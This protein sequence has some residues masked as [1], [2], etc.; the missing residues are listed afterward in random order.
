MKTTIV[1][2]TR[3][4]IIKLAPIIKKLDKRRYSVV[5]SGQHFEHKMGLQFIDELE[6]PK[7]N[8][9][10]KLTGKTP[11]IQISEIILKLSKILSDEKP[12]TV[13]V[14]GDTN[15][16]LAASICSIKQKIPISHVE[17]GLRSYDWRM[18]EEHN[19]IAVDH[20]S[21]VLFA[22]TSKSKQN[23]LSEN[24]HGSIH[25]TGN[26]VIDAIN[27]YSRISKQK[28][29]LSMDENFALLTLH[30][31]ENVDNKKSLSSIIKG[32]I[33]SNENIVFPVHPRTKKCLIEFDLFS[34]LKKSNNIKLL[35]V[36]GYFEMLELMKKCS[37]I[38]TDSG[39]IQEESTAPQ[40][41]KKVL[42][43]RKTTDRPETVEY[44]MSELIGLNSKTISNKIKKTF[45]NP[46]ISTRKTPY[47]NGNAS[48]KIIEILKKYYS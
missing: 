35:D 6:L 37:F 22:P 24:V 44:K 1:L 39:G 21:E 46:K 42:V 45:E 36:V 9:T 32:L 12:D 48:S 8:H 17:S 13:I 11:S 25:V 27:M 41:R 29:Q 3:P 33:D 40:I 14:Q 28:S 38:V 16:V 43:L 47:G 18:P 34:K 7:P 10:M 20:I 30:R 15:T 23:L 4:E 2:G 31:A 26:T 5:F 19:R